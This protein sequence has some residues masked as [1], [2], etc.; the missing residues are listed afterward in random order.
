MSYFCKRVESDKLDSKSDKCYFVGY[1]KESF[2]YYLYN[3]NEQKVFVSRHAAFLEKE[4]ILEMASGSQIELD[5]VREPQ[6]RKEKE[7]EQELIP[8]DDAVELTTQDTQGDSR[9][10]RI[11]HPPQRYDDVFII[12][13]DEPTTYNEVLLDKDS[14]KWL[15]AMNSE[16]DSMCENEVWTLVDPP[17]G[18]KPIGCK[19][20]FKKKTDM[21]GKVSTYKARLVAKGYL[22]KYGIDY[23]ETFSPVV[24]LKS[25][26]I[27]LAIA[28][29]YDYEIW[30][31]DVM[32]AFLNKHLQEEVYLTQPEGFVSKDPNKVCKLQKS[33]YGLKQAPRS[34]NIRFDE[35]IKMFGFIKNEDEPCVYK[36]ISGSIVV[37][38]ILYVDDILLIGNDIP[39]LQSVKEW[40]S[41]NFSMK[42]LGEAAYILGVKIYRD[43]SN[44]LLGLSQSTY[45]DKMLKKYSMDQS[46][47]GYLPMS[48]GI[49]LSKDMCPKTDV[50]VHN[51]QNVP[52]ASAVGSIMYVMMCT[53]PDVS[54]VLS[55]TSKFQANPGESYW[56]AVKNILK[57]LRR[58]KD[59]FMIYGGAKLQVRGFTDASFQSD[60]D[61]CKSQSGYIFTLNGGVV[62][63]NSSKQVTTADSTTE[64]EYIAASEVAKEA[65]WIK[66]VPTKE[67][68]ANPLTKPLSQKKHDS[69]VFSYGLKNKHNWM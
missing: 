60:K 15:Q 19:W 10:S 37:F 52:Y 57:Y 39:S 1:P 46:K 23:D 24:M 28:A 47:K 21:D 7:V 16:M 63:W 48:H 11:R 61:D 4:F 31:M 68:M 14:K 62:S 65:V 55:V 17:I 58:T 33:I 59:L 34:W 6:S 53:R 35:I 36:K 26:R 64:A 3:P 67:N 49:Y 45:I 30:K 38:L 22:Q 8:H 32:T 66:K 69:H 56:K 2:G 5:E 27:I 29:Y 54:Y 20:V 41:K 18:T 13:N 44:K 40:L 12:N 51:M 50:E 25:I 42:D 9:S 43:R